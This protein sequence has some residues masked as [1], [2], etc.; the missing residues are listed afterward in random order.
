LIDIY[1]FIAGSDKRRS[2]RMLMR[3]HMVKMSVNLRVEVQ[4]DTG[5]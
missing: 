2:W 4:G 5:L 1:G 3:E